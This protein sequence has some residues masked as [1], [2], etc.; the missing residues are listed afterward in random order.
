MIER[1][2]FISKSEELKAISE[3]SDFCQCGELKADF[4]SGRTGREIFRIES[5]CRFK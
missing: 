2:K 3:F 1:K 5:A 4:S